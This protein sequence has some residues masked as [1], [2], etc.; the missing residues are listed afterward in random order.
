MP[1]TDWSVLVVG[2]LVGEN[3]VH[4]L[5]FHQLGADSAGYCRWHLDHSLGG[6]VEW[7]V[8][9]TSSLSFA[10]G[11]LRAH[12]KYSTK[13]MHLRHYAREIRKRNQL[14]T[15]HITSECRLL[16]CLR[17]CNQSPGFP[18]CRLPAQNVLNVE[19]TGL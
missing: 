6:G 19:L 2:G 11:L 4:G 18:F 17:L 16:R 12:A 13:C 9:V 3:K 1:R 10:A 15:L 7:A 8:I 14:N 5:G